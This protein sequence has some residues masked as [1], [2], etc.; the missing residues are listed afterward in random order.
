LFQFT[1]GRFDHWDI[2]SYLIFFLLAF[3]SFHFQRPQQDI[4]SP[5]TFR[6]FTFLICFLS[7]YLAHV[8]Y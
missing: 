3:H 1:K 5:F 8:N 7:V 6:G 2:A 4:M